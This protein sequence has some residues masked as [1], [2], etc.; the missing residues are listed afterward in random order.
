MTVRVACVVHCYAAARSMEQLSIYLYWTKSRVARYHNVQ[1]QLRLQ[2]SFP[3]VV[4][5]WSICPYTRT[6][7][8]QHR[9]VR[10]AVEGNIYSVDILCVTGQCCAVLQCI[11][12]LYCVAN[13]KLCS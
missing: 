13:S 5:S 11:R 1:S 3:L 9:C 4:L 8:M 6:P 12:Q 10:G 7:C 2:S